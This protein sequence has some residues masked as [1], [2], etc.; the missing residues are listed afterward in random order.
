MTF[1]N[2]I[3]KSE[4]HNAGT[5]NIRWFQ[6]TSCPSCTGCG[7]CSQCTAA[8]CCACPGNWASH[9]QSTCH[10]TTTG[11]PWSWSYPLKIGQ[12]LVDCL[13]TKEQGRLGGSVSTTKS[14][15]YWSV[16]QP[17]SC[18]HRH[19]QHPKPHHTTTSS[20]NRRHETQEFVLKINSRHKSLTK[21]T[22]QYYCLLLLLPELETFL[23]PA[24]WHRWVA[25]EGQ[26]IDTWWGDEAPQQPLGF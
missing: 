8:C 14:K 17:L 3:C 9:P 21:L 19:A 16:A 13:K 22:C 25:V 11:S 20:L 2:L 23:F 10:S 4:C 26:R 18:L 7:V 6:R 15:Q 5:L 24:N 12:A 1:Y